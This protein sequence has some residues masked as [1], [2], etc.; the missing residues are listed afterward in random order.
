VTSD[1]GP[2]QLGRP[3]DHSIDARVLEATRL[4]LQERGFEDTT[5]RAIAEASGVHA[6]AIYRRWR[7]RTEIIEMAVYPGISSVV[8][9]PS[10][11]LRRDLRRFIRAHLVAFGAP[12]TKAAM[13]GLLAAYQAS[14]RSGEPEHW[15]AVSARPQFLDIL[16]AAPSGSVDPGVDP[17]DV[18]DILLGAMIAR[19]LVPTV[20]ARNRPMEQLVD[21][22]LRLVQPRTPPAAPASF[23]QSPPRRG[24]RTP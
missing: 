8:V 7:S 2:P 3:R 10:G 4:L 6:S 22:V 12:E 9:R 21:T 11:D 13:P 16:L 23:A 18:F 14:G 17:N 15:L 24:Q 5:I 1:Q 19:T 20:A